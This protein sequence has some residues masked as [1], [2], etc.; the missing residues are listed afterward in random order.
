MNSTLYTYSLPLKEGGVRRGLLLFDKGTGSWGE[1]AP[2]PGRSPESFENARDQLLSLFSAPQTHLFPS[3]Q[4]CLESAL[5]PPPILPL[6]VPIWALQMYHPSILERIEGF[7]HVKVKIGHLSPSQ[8]KDALRTLRGMCH[9]RIDCNRAFSY[10]Q[11][12]QI[13]SNFDN[14][15]HPFC[16]EEPTRDLSLLSQFPL[17]FALDE[18][19]EENPHFPLNDCPHLTTL[20]LKPTLWGGKRG[21]QPFVDWAA[22]HGK[23]TIFTGAYESGVGTLQ[24]ASLAQNSGPVGLQT[25]TSL[26]SDLFDPPLPLST[27]V[28]TLLN[29]PQIQHHLIQEIAHGTLHLPTL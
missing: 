28:F 11:A 9:L 16:I 26:K 19:L 29:L 3:V 17:P 21:C 22:Q 1:A 5:A 14:G 10:T 23:E 18:T 27:P 2:L 24:I 8:A 12:L 20:I 4:F 25:Y 7:S 6:S 15:G 13:F